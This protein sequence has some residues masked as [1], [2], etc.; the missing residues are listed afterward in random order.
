M[1]QEFRWIRKLPWSVDK[2]FVLVNL[3]VFTDDRREQIQGVYPYE[4]KVLKRKDF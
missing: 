1:G 2:S 4:G 3:F